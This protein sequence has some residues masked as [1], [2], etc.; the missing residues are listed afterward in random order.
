MVFHD[1][2]L[3]AHSAVPAARAPIA[4]SASPR[5][6]QELYRAGAPFSGA[7][8]QA[9]SAEGAVQH[10]IADVYAVAW[11]RQSSAVR[12]R[13]AM[14]LLPCRAQGRAVL[15][16]ETA[17]WVHL[18]GAAGSRLTLIS[19]SLRRRGGDAEMWQVHQVALSDEDVSVVS[20]VGVTTP[21]RTAADLFLGLGAAD[22]RR[23]LD[24]L[25]AESI[26]T[27]RPEVAAAAG[28]HEPA[29]LR[30]WWLVADL[31]HARRRD[32]DA[33]ALTERLLARMRGGRT[34]EHRLELIP[35]LVAQCASRR[36]PTVR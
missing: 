19:Q 14:M 13:A 9:L 22:G 8:L 21:L 6:L 11:L 33:E 15:C 3:A 10:L 27:R 26:Y 32:V 35:D 34:H 4:T 23:A 28:V 18:G 25:A 7:E 16:G 31:L 5:P 1:A 24:V 30:R 17:A 2:G 12:A 36:R 29:W 20:G